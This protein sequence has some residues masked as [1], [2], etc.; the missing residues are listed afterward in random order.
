MLYKAGAWETERSYLPV[1][2]QKGLWLYTVDSL[3]LNP[4]QSAFGHFHDFP[5][6]CWW[7]IY[8]K[9]TLP[10]TNGFTPWKFN[11][12]TEN[13]PSFKRKVVFHSSIICQGKLAVT[14]RGCICVK[15]SWQNPSNISLADFS[16]ELLDERKVIQHFK[17]QLKRSSQKHDDWVAWCIA[18]KW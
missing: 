10:K 1:S 15:T 6:I 5:W 4:G 18:K 2:S 16:K 9:T 11:I 7:M 17:L 13:L 8:K 12:A 3:D 14:F